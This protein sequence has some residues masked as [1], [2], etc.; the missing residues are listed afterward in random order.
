MLRCE[1]RIG[2]D[3]MLDHGMKDRSGFNDTHLGRIGL[4]SAGA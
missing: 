2:F 1:A 4:Q 3:R